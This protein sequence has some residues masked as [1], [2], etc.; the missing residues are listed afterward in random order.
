MGGL[1]YDTTNSGSSVNTEFV[2]EVGNGEM[3]WLRS[4]AV[5]IQMRFEELRML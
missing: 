3:G 4:F 5:I 2:D 1:S